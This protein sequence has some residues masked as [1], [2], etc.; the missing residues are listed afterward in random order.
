MNPFETGMGIPVGEIMKYETE[1]EIK[2]M[3]EQMKMF[4]FKVMVTL[5]LLPFGLMGFVWLKF[6]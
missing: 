6:L 4:L 2:I 5:F 1:N 3:L